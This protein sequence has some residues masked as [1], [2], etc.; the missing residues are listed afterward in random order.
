VSEFLLT[1]IELGDLSGFDLGVVVAIDAGY[2]CA[3]HA[4]ADEAHNVDDLVLHGKLLAEVLVELVD[5][6]RRILRGERD[7]VELRLAHARTM[8]GAR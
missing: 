7:A 5:R 3:N 1:E 2:S 8:A 6:V 4:A